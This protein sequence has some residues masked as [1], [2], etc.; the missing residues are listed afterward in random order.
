[1]IDIVYANAYTE[2]LEILKYVSKDEYNKISKE[3]LDLFNENKN[4]NYKFNYDPSKTLQEQNVSPKAKTI[5]AI[6]FRDYWA[7]EEQRNRI[8]EKERKDRMLLEQEKSAKYDIN[9]IFKNNKNDTFQNSSNLPIEQVNRF[10]K[11][12]NFIKRIIK[13]VVNKKD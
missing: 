1:M 10:T 5:I 11:I 2:V 4:T 9:N 7:T 13:K 3:L 12:V 6:L 8:L